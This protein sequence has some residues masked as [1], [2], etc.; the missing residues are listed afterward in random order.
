MTVKFLDVNTGTVCLALNMPM[1]PSTTASNAV[2][3]GGSTEFAGNVTLL[4]T[5][6][7]TESTVK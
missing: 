7:D 3:V 1:N 6:P 2:K 5:M 4:D